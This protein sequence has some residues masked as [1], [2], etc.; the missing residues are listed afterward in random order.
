MY[1]LTSKIRRQPVRSHS[2]G[3]VNLKITFYSGNVLGSQF[4]HTEGRAY[5]H[6]HYNS[7]QELI[8]DFFSLYLLFSFT[9]FSLKKSADEE[10]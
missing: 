3:N 7:E 9:I 4:I 2:P 5:G 8:V 6:V 10:S 1:K